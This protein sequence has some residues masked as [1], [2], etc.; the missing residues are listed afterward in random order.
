MAFEGK[1]RGSY[2]SEINFPQTM[3]DPW[4]NHFSAIVE[5]SDAD[6]YSCLTTSIRILLH[7]ACCILP[8]FCS[9]Y[10][11]AGAS[12]PVIRLPA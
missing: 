9:L 7:I 8:L 5:R 6:V 10:F 3:R 11:Y 12:I 4:I 2:W 1:M